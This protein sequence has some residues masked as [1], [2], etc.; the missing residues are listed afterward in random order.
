MS[1][2]AYVRDADGVLLSIAQTSDAPPTGVSRQLLSVDP[3]DPAWMYDLVTR[4]F[5][6]RPA[7]VII[8]RLDDIVTNLNY[9]DFQTVWSA[10]SAT[11][12]NQLKQAMI[13]LL[14]RQ[15]FRADTEPLEL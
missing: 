5:I 2:F 6:A 9:A 8:D 4:A 3:T 12:K 10:L 14:G 7:K 13:R 1:W 11:R 15:R